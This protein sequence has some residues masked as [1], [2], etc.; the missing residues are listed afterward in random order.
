M[1]RSVHWSQA[2][3]RSSRRVRPQAESGQRSEDLVVA[4]LHWYSCFRHSLFETITEHGD[5]GNPASSLP[6]L[7]S[8]SINR[9]SSKKVSIAENLNCDYSDDNITDIE[10]STSQ[11]DI[12]SDGGQNDKTWSEH[13]VKLF[14]EILITIV[15]VLVSYSFRYPR[16]CLVILAFVTICNVMYFCY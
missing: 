5:H 4:I 8:N 2:R 15:F 7:P 13:L 16:V 12:K 11:S 6:S 14:L 10:E 3:V 1:P 9:K